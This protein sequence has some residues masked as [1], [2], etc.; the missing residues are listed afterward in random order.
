MAQTAIL[1]EPKPLRPRI[2]QAIKESYAG[3]SKR[4]ESRFPSALGFDK[5]HV[6]IQLYY[7]QCNFPSSYAIR[8]DRKGQ[9]EPLMLSPLM[10]SLVC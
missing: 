1:L 7:S 5:G 4:L 9:D 6:P 10:L 2:E 3:S 8:S